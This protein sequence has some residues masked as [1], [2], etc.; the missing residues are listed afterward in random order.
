MNI[1]LTNSFKDDYVFEFI[2]LPVAYNERE[3]L[4]QGISHIGAIV[5]R[6]NIAAKK[7]LKKARFQKKSTFDVQKDIYEVKVT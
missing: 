2:N 7:V 4:D 1:G 5:N 3:L 6:K